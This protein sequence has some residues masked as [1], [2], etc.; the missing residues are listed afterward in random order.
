[1]NPV[2][3]IDSPSGL[4]LNPEPTSPVRLSKRAGIVALVIVFVV[5]ALIGYGIYTRGQKQF[6]VGFQPDETRGITAATDAGKIVAARVPNR[7]T[8]R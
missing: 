6:Q 3:D 5:V 7:P 1:M 4:D 2:K 8:F